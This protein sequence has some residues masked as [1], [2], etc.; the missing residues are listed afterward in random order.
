MLFSPD[1]SGVMLSYH[2]LLLYTISI[3]SVC[4]AHYAIV[5]GTQAVLGTA[6]PDSVSLTHREASDRRWAA[7]IPKSLI[8]NSELQ[9]G[10]R[11]MCSLL[12]GGRGLGSFNGSWRLIAV[13]TLY[14]AFQT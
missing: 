11:S 13:A 5:P 1:Q 4:G 2:N 8:T 14:P 7:H 9:Q 6:G 3:P 10:R 12:W